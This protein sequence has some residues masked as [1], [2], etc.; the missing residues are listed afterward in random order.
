MKRYLT[1][2][3]H[4][5]LR[6]SLE[7]GDA[8]LSVPRSVARQFFL[9]V[10]NASIVET[11]GESMVLQKSLIWLGI[12]GHATLFI[13]SLVSI[14]YYFGWMATVGIPLVGIFWTILAGLTGDK[15][16]MLHGSIG[17][18]AAV[19]L[20]VLIPIGYAVPL[21]LFATSLWLHRSCYMLAQYWVTSL[22]VRSFP[23]YDMLVEH[24]DV[25]DTGPNVQTVRP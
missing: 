3:E 1:E 5:E 6:R 22:V 12:I 16:S 17:L 4:E 7:R 18:A 14:G 15:G 8:T 21:I 24:I 23:A 2:S 13:A 9:R 20:A 25:E 10:D 19:L 11:T